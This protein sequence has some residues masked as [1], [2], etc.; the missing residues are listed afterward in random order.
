MSVRSKF[1][2]WNNAGKFCAQ[3]AADYGE[4]FA[5]ELAETRRRL[6]REFIALVTLAVGT[7]F[8]LS[9][10]CVAG[11]ASAW[12]TPYFFLVLWGVAVAWVAVSLCA[13]L[14]VRAQQP[15][16]SFAVVQSQLQR[17]VATLKE[18]LK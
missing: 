14:F 4:L 6:V 1:E 5:I 10:L 18:A 15:G 17:D 9:F 8:S 13:W 7:L 3:R 11:I 2:Q 16:R 12:Q